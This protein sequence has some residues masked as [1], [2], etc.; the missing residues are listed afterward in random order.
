MSPRED[1]T[2]SSTGQSPMQNLNR[3][4]LRKRTEGLIV[5]CDAAI[6]RVKETHKLMLD[7]LGRDRAK[8]VTLLEDLK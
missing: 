2:L 4:E 3:E 6:A 7:V 5:T 8:L 1:R